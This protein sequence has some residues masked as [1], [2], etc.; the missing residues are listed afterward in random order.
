MADG[1]AP[2]PL[3]AAMFAAG[4]ALLLWAFTA[5]YRPTR[6]ADPK[7]PGPVKGSGQ[8]HEDL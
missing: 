1:G 2:L 4:T 5:H 3:A 8:R 7:G 6:A